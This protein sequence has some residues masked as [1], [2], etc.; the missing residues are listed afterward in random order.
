MP[1]VCTG[2]N[3]IR[4][5]CILSASVSACGQVMCCAWVWKKGMDTR[6]TKRSVKAGFIFAAVG[7]QFTIQSR[8]MQFTQFNELKRI[9]RT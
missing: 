1:R 2:A 7:C 6:V 5:A 9:R 4:S 8:L 3:P